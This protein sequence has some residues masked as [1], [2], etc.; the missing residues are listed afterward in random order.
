MRKHFSRLKSAGKDVPVPFGVQCQQVPLSSDMRKS[1][2]NPCVAATVSSM[3]VMHELAQ[4]AAL[5]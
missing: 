4:S 5:S 2:L 1:M 3:H